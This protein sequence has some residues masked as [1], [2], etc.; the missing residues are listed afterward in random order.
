MKVGRLKRAI[1]RLAVVMVAIGA[2]AMVTAA[3]AQA[4]YVSVSTFGVLGNFAYGQG[5]KMHWQQSDN[6][7]TMEAHVMTTMLVLDGPP[8]GHTISIERKCLDSNF[9]GGVYVMGCSSGVNKH[10]RW[11]FNARGVRTVHGWTGD[12]NAQSYEIINVATGRCLDGNTADAYTLPC[13]NGDNQRW[14]IMP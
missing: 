6:N 8:N 4:Q 7:I 9:S 12:F 5:Y 11:H 13:N 2:P 3:P 1:A 10:Q 14:Y